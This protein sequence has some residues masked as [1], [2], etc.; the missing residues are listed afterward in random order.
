MYLANAIAYDLE[1]SKNAPSHKVL[2]IPGKAAFLKLTDVQ[3]DIGISICKNSMV[4]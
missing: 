4:Q 1:I 3:I 2:G